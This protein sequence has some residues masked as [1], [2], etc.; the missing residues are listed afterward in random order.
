MHLRDRRRDVSDFPPGL[1]TVQKL[2]QHAR[3]CISQATWNTPLNKKGLP[4]PCHK[5]IIS[6]KW[7]LDG[8]TPNMLLKFEVGVR[9]FFPETVL[10]Q[11]SWSWFEMFRKKRQLMNLFSLVITLKHW[12]LEISAVAI[13][14]KRLTVRIL[15]PYLRLNYWNMMAIGHI[16]SLQE[17]KWWI[18]NG[19]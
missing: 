15:F 9:G 19:F 7:A 4:I 3:S 8:M 13:H 16:N 5:W 6:K 14:L 1:P 2:P 17:M 10:Q 18:L 12:F 11:T